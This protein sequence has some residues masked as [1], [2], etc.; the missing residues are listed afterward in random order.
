MKYKLIIEVDVKRFLKEI[1]D[2]QGGEIDEKDES[3]IQ[4]LIIGDCDRL[5]DAIEV[6]KIEKIKENE[7]EVNQQVENFEGLNKES[8]GR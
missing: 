4:A 6:L 8:G 3:L 1:Y 2:N 7:N 5:S